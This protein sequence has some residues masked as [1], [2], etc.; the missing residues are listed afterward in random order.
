VFSF[1][2]PLQSFESIVGAIETLDQQLARTLL[3]GSRF[4]G[5]PMA[6]NA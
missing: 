5:I 4:G 1:T 3:L 2:A 6:P